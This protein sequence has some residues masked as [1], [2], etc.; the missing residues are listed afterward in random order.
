MTATQ[1][2]YGEI[3]Q[4]QHPTRSARQKHAALVGTPL[5]A[6]GI[7]LA[8]ANLRP[9]VTSAA[10]VL[11]EVRDDVGASAMWASALTAV[12]VVCFGIAAVFAPWLER[13]LGAARAVGLALAVLTGGLALRIV[14]GQYAVLGG[15]FVAAAGIAVGNVL[16]PVVVKGSFPHAIG[17]VTGIYTAALSAGGGIGA[18]TPAL[19]P[20]VGGW[21]G[22]LGAWAALSAA[23]L[24]V[25][26]FGARHGSHDGV[27]V[28]H[29]RPRR[30]MLRS[31][32]AWVVTLFFGMQ[33]C[34]AYILMGWL[35]EFF[36]AHGI[37]RTEAGLMLAFI[38]LIGIPLSFVIPVY[39]LNRPSQ[40][41]WVIALACFSLAG[42]AGLVVAPAAAPWLWT[43]LLGIGMSIFPIAIGV[44][45]LRTRET[46][47]TT[48]L[49]A[50]VQ[51]YGYLIA[52]SGPF[53]FGILH[54]ATGNWTVPLVLLGAVIIVEGALGYWAGRPRFV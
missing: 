41:G 32:L 28:T 13:R 48:A 24:I 1:T 5:L 42:V 27:P 52:A 16:I 53:L 38:N 37:A 34:F 3:V 12:P 18:F 22:A 17:R 36:V 11:G 30:S 51:G 20:F 40:S 43:V 39:A 46:S 6:V 7:A 49:S 33:A 45:A 15:T 4:R 50:M 31:P 21:R 2:D 44:I 8:A 14:D 9:A 54:A 25:W 19:E 10:S 35:A 47:E 29:E 23:A 26:L